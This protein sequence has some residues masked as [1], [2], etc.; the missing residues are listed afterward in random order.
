MKTR[1]LTH[2]AVML[3]VWLSSYFGTAFVQWS[4]DPLHWGKDVRGL[5]LTV[6]ALLSLCANILL[7]M[8]WS[9]YQ[10][11]KRKQTEP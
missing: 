2:L 6:S 7:V 1:I 11:Y 10:E 3:F 9:E 8:A 4:F 5:F